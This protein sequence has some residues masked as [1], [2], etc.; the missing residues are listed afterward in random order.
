LS[1]DLVA[2]YRGLLDGTL[3][4]DELRQLHDEL[5]DEHSPLSVY[6]DGLTQDEVERELMEAQPP[7]S[8]IAPLAPLNETESR[9]LFVR[10]ERAAIATA[11]PNATGA[12]TNGWERLFGWLSWRS[13]GLGVAVGAAAVSA[14]FV[15]LP[16]E[17]GRQKG[18]PAPVVPSLQLIFHVGRRELNRP[19]VVERGIPG[20]RYRADSDILLSYEIA[21]EGHVCL[22]HRTPSKELE[23]LD[24]DSDPAKAG[25]HEL[26]KEG[27]VQAVRLSDGP[28][29]H[30]F[31]AV[32]NAAPILCPSVVDDVLLGRRTDLLV[33]SFEVEVSP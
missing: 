12:H 21:A 33:D 1:Q 29:I 2:R 8:G 4:R 11:T 31:F 13:A 23:R 9:A 15:M 27:R 5:S 24:S 30:G 10:I 26:R 20:A 3:S 22:A 17:S 28:G 19:L 6:I 7:L 18:R 32:W 16:S 14:L 25:H